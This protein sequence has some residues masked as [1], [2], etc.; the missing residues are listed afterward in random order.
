MIALGAVS[1]MY[2]V[3]YRTLVGAIQVFSATKQRLTKE[4]VM[5]KVQSE[6]GE[7]F[8]MRCQ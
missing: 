7:S 6:P 3:H 8:S 1:S 5:T 4:G 2:Y